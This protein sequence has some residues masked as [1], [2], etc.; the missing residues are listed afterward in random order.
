MSTFC[1]HGRGIIIVSMRARGIGWGD[2]GQQRKNVFLVFPLFA[3]Y[4]D[5]WPDRLRFES[6][7]GSKGI[8]NARHGHNILWIVRVWLDFLT[9][10]ANMCFHQ[11]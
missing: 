8:A 4:P 3:L 5:W 10:M 7:R 1:I 6:D 11:P 2:R 9:Q